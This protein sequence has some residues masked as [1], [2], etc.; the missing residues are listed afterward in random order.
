MT[1]TTKPRYMQLD[2]SALNKDNLNDTDYTIDY[3]HQKQKM[4]VQCSIS[5]ER[6]EYKQNSDRI[7]S[8]KMTRSGNS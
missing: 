6:Y 7:E 4:V 2:L 3:D 5:K 1:M 8:Y